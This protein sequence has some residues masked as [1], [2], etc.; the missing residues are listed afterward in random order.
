MQTTFIMLF[1]YEND[2]Y[3]SMRDFLVRHPDFVELSLS[4]D[5]PKIRQ[6]AKLFLENDPYKMR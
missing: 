1:I 6:R 5:D 4:N 3:V 2:P